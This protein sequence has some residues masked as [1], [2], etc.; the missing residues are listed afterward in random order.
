MS[1]TLTIDRGNTATKMSLWRDGAVISAV[2]VSGGPDVDDVAD[3]VAGKEVAGVAVSAVA[4]LDEAVVERLKAISQRFIMVDAH[5]PMAMKFNY[6]SLDLLGPDRVA[7]AAGA[8]DLYPG[9]HLLVADLGTAAT[10]DYVDDSGCYR[11]GVISAGIGLR[12]EALHG[13][14]SRLPHVEP[15]AVPLPGP[16]AFIG[17]DTVSA[18]A[19]AAVFGIVGE[20]RLYLSMLPAGTRVVLTGGDSALVSETLEAMKIHVTREDNLVGHGLNRILLYNEP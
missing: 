20:I 17:E 1:L 18:M 10:F 6:Q 5:T 2:S 8:V 15:V 12:L 11:G 9:E 14:T 13:H 3:F 7:A 19:N 16:N 4:Q